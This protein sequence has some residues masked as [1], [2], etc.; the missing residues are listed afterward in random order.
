MTKKCEI[1]N[2]G[3]FIPDL[4]CC[5]ACFAESERVQEQMVREFNENFR[6]LDRAAPIYREYRET[7]SDP[8]REALQ[9][10]LG[11]KL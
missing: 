5:S 10:I 3:L 1:C 7:R 11:M 9:D 6:R 2:E 4:D 8:L